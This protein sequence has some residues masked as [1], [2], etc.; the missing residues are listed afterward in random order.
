MKDEKEIIKFFITILARFVIKNKLIFI[1]PKRKTDGFLVGIEVEEFKH[2]ISEL[3]TT[4]FILEHIQE[5]E[6]MHLRSIS[7]S[8]K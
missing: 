1:N 2:C 3:E 6:E 8:R 4:N 7:N 5:K